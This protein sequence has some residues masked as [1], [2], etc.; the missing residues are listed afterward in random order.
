VI[1]CRREHAGWAIPAGRMV[2]ERY[3]NGVGNAAAPGFGKRWED[4]ERISMIRVILAGR[5]GN[6]LFQY[7]VG[8]H[9]SLRN[10]CPLL[11]DLSENYQPTDIFA[12]KIEKCLRMLHIQAGIYNP[13]PLTIINK[14]LER[15]GVGTLQSRRDVFHEMDEGF[16]PGVFHL[17]DGSTIRGFFQNPGYFQEIQGILRK[18]LELRMP[19]LEPEVLAYE[20]KIRESTSIAVHFRRKDYQHIRQYNFLDIRY[21]TNAIN[22][23]KER[24]DPY[25]LFVFSDDPDWCERNLNFEHMQMVKL[26]PRIRNPLTDLYLM[27]QCKHQIISNSTFSWWGG[28]LN[29]HSHKCVIAPN[30]WCDTGDRKHDLRTVESIYPDGWVRLPVV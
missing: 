17:S 7:A 10:R 8:R 23:I 28:W 22:F 6:V 18:D 27:Q 25:Q 15:V 21:Y 1:H 2:S 24:I 12:L 14:A 30:K 13:F 16:N 26:N 29:N 9:V 20:K 5:L 19:F 3:P 11:L 4:A